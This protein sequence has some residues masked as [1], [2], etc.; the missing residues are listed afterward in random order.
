MIEIDGSEGGGQMLRTALGLSAVTGKPFSMHNIRSSRPQPGIRVQ[1]LEATNA[2]ATICDAEVEGNVMDSTE[3]SFK[4]KEIKSG[5]VKIKVGTAGSVGLILQAVLIPASQSKIRVMVEGGAT[6][7]AWAQP[8]D[9]LWNVTIPMLGKMGYN[10]K[11]RNVQHGFYPKGGARVEVV[12]D[13]AELKPVEILDKGKLIA[14]KGVSVASSSLER[15]QV[16]ARQADAAK[17]LIKESLKKEI[18]I[19]VLYK[20]TS[21]PGSGITLWAECENSVIGG[22]SF[23]EKTKRAEIVGAEAAQRLIFELENSAVDS[24]TADQLMPYMAMAGK[25]K[26]KTSKITDHMKTNASI[27]EKFLDVKFTFKDNIISVA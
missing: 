21:C 7:G 10:V 27:I 6:Y 8:M 17:Y 15:P 2:V 1:H 16:A 18:D 23:G 12:S 19:L 14:L 4:P 24:Y 13:K 26:I 3:L 22:D 25:G 9:S 5:R 20:E 11:V